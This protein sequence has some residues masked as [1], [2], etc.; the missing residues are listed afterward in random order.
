MNLGAKRDEHSPGALDEGEVVGGVERADSVDD[1]VQVSIGSPLR[2]RRGVGRER[3]RVAREF[4][5]VG[6]AGSAG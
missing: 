4:E 5:G 6:D 2:P 1:I 3:F